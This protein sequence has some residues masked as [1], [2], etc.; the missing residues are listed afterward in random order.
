MSGTFAL[1][2]TV[3]SKIVRGAEPSIFT[4]ALCQRYWWGEVRAAG[5]PKEATGDFRHRINSP[6]GM[7][8]PARMLAM[9]KRSPVPEIRIDEARID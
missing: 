1:A 4:G 2:E 9:L 3:V 8:S 7:E 5:R 6:V